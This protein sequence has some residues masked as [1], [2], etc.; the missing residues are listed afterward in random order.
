MSE[1]ED[2]LDYIQEQM[3]KHPEWTADVFRAVTNGISL[4]QKTMEDRLGKL[5]QALVA[6]F[7]FIKGTKLPPEWKN[8][9]T[10]FILE[11]FADRKSYSP[12]EHTVL[13]KMLDE[14]K[15]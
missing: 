14:R 4:A 5:N 10:D 11:A 13:Q 15:G 1:K 7:L 3:E 2:F 6:S 9:C 8:Q 12:L